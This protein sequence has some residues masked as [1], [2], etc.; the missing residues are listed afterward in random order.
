MSYVL[1][2]LF[3][4]LIAAADQVT[5]YL[6]VSVI[7][8]G[9]TKAFIPGLIRFTYVRNTG[10]AWSMLSDHTWLLIAVS[11]V[12]FALIIT[13]M[14]KKYITGTGTLWSLFAVMGGGLGN[15]I[16]RVRL[17]Y[18]V[19]MIETEFISFPVFNVA[20]CF[21]TCGA[22]A[23]CVF[24]LLDEKKEKG[25]RQAQQEAAGEEEA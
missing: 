17:G 11:V 1:M 5:K 22:I 21:I 10:G 8:L 25:R 15:L 2:S 18:V 13:A 24:V 16:D 3:A 4:L 7:E 19:D 14:A 9:G 12:F 6:T 23:M 20:D